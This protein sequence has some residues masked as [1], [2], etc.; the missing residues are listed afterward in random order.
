MGVDHLDDDKN[1][2]Q[3]DGA[4]PH[5]DLIQCHPKYFSGRV[6]DSTI[7][8]RQ[9]LNDICLLRLDH[10]LQFGNYINKA[11]LPWR[12]HDSNITNKELFVSKFGYKESRELKKIDQILIP[13]EKCKQEFYSYRE[14]LS[15]CTWCADHYGFDWCNPRSGSGLVYKDLSDCDIVVALLSRA[16]YSTGFGL[17]V[18]ISAYREWIEQ[19]MTRFGHPVGSK[20]TAN[21]KY[22]KRNS[23]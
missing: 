9:T 20:S 14:G 13:N 5:A 2:P 4:L 15:L 1:K 21:Y 22:P 7:S 16:T 6:H 8:E 11:A 12:A 19:T 10:T 17:Y 23:D 18:N 3:R